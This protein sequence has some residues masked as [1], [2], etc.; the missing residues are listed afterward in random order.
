MRKHLLAVAVILTAGTGCD[1]VEFGGFLDYLDR[2]SSLGIPTRGYDPTGRI[3]TAR[4]TI[5]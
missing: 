2:I 4:P 5:C 3:V 1:N